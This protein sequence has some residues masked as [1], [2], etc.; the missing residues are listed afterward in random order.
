MTVFN[1]A[2]L[3]K[4]S[5]DLASAL[6]RNAQDALS[7]GARA[8]RERHLKAVRTT[9]PVVSKSI[10]SRTPAQQLAFDRKLELEQIADERRFISGLINPNLDGGKT[11]QRRVARLEELKAREQALK[12]GANP[13]S[14]TAQTQTATTETTNPFKSQNIASKTEDAEPSPDE[15]R[16]YIDDI[17]Y[18]YEQP[19]DTSSEAIARKNAFAQMPQSELM[20]KWGQLNIE[21]ER[22][23]KIQ[24]LLNFNQRIQ[25]EAARRKALTVIPQQADTSAAKIEP[26]LLNASEADI[27][28]ARIIKLNKR[29]ESSDLTTQNYVT[30][31]TEVNRL[32]AKLASINATKMAA[33]DS[34]GL[35]NL[36]QVYLEKAAQDGIDPTL[37]APR[38]FI[39]QADGV[40]PTL[41]RNKNGLGIEITEVDKTVVDAEPTLVD[42]EPTQ[43][44][45]P[46]QTRM[47]QEIEIQDADIESIEKASTPQVA[48]VVED[49][50]IQ[51]LDNDMLIAEDDGIQMLDDGAVELIEETPVV[52][53]ATPEPEH[54]SVP[55]SLRIASK[56]DESEMKPFDEQKTGVRWAGKILKKLRAIMP[57][58]ESEMT[59]AKVAN[60]KR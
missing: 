45:I 38:P 3:R 19:I 22:D 29:L 16:S 48:R 21:S 15:V 24:R 52:A 14:E 46:L 23:A 8:L 35:I 31:T 42:A 59:D 20:I 41:V 55:P 54:V 25:D 57:A 9:E 53:K 49:D 1:A 33:H 2:V 5:G 27:I 39:E 44:D 10:I 26:E 11:L 28:Q 40:A 18:K 12:N 58:R 32:E 50:N 6:E 51:M 60:A 4:G 36:R 47:G 34:G 17:M 7:A 30:L 37:L 13:F 43:V 56:T